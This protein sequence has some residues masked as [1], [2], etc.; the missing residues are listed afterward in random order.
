MPVSH[1]FLAQR[2]RD[3]PLEY[4]VDHKIAR[5][6][7]PPD[8]PFHDRTLARA[9]AGAQDERS[10]L[11]EI[12]EI[13]EAASPLLDDATGLEQALALL[14]SE[15][16]GRISDLL[17]WRDAMNRLIFREIGDD[18]HDPAESL[19]VQ[20]STG[21]EMC[22]V[23]LALAKQ[24]ARQLAGELDIHLPAPLLARPNIPSLGS[25]PV[26]I[27]EI[28]DLEDPESASG[29]TRVHK[30]LAD[31]AGALTWKWIHGPTGA[32]P[33]SE[34]AAAFAEIAL[35]ADPARFWD[36]LSFLYRTYA[37]G[38]PG[39]FPEIPGVPEKGSDALLLASEDRYQEHVR[40]DMAMVNVCAVPPIRPAFVIGTRPFL[41]LDAL[42]DLRAEVERLA[43]GS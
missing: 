39:L 26:E 5:L 4:L 29:H 35:E 19:E 41:G 22:L 27:V 10:L 8:L 36:S 38:E 42:D 24:G 30:E 1:P 13:A 32:F 40:R 16:S 31:K 37:L 33:Q 28:G 20:I 6:L 15:D 21:V 2:I 23:A 7:Q 14:P 11:Q 18:P 34:Y 17:A 9:L 25:G 3:L 12:H 43:Q